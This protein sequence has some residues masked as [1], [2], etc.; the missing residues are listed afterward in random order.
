MNRRWISV[1][2]VCGLLHGCVESDHSGNDAPPPLSWTAERVESAFQRLCT[3]Q[4]VCDGYTSE[5]ADS[6]CALF[7]S[8]PRS[9]GEVSAQCQYATSLALDC[10]ADA[11]SEQC[12]VEEEACASAVENGVSICGSID[13]MMPKLQFKFPPDL[14]RL[15]DRACVLSASCGG[16]MRFS[17]DDL[18]LAYYWLSDPALPCLNALTSYIDCVSSVSSCDDSECWLARRSM[19]DA[20]ESN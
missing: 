3:K 12:V 19:I 16:A 14:A 17:C 2:A 20:C 9:A 11:T 1:L 4:F 13:V 8:D 5:E 18:K 7:E 10:L 6:L 15:T